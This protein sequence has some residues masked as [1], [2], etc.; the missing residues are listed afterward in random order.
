M[1]AETSAKLTDSLS[2]TATGG[3][4]QVYLDRTIHYA[5]ED[6][7][8]KAS[9]RAIFE[10]ALQDQG[11]PSAE[12]AQYLKKMIRAALDAEE[13]ST[14]EGEL[15]LLLRTPSV[16]WRAILALVSLVAASP[17]GPVAVNALALANRMDVTD[18]RRGIAELR[19]RGFL[20]VPKGVVS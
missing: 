18:V 9:V 14:P 3:A 19:E 11:A 7:T 6:E 4:S 12:G 20:A 10:Q 1:K 5:L 13:K 16:S 17:D 8:L 15:Q 2:V